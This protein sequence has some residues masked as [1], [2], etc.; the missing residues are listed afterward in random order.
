MS[1]RM[2]VLL[3]VG[4]WL[5]GTI[6]LVILIGGSGENAEFAP[7]EEFRLTPWIPIQV[8]PFDLSINKAV[9][10]L[11]IATALTVITMT[12]IARRMVDKPNRVQAA[13]EAVFTLS[14]DTITRDNMSDEMAV[15]WFPFIGT[16]FLFILFSNLIGYLPLPTNTGETISVFGLQIP[17]L[18]IYAA[19]ANLSVPLALTLVVWIA[20]QVEGVRAKG[21]IAYVKG[22]IPQGSPPALVPMIGFIEVLS[23]IMRI[24][25]LSV[26]LFAN[27]LAGHMLILFMGGGLAVLLGLAALG[28]LTA[29]IA[30]VFFLFEVVI[31][32]GLQAFIFATLTS[33]YLGEAVAEGH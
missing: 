8:G 10:Y 28:W 11:A 22:W 24:V 21:P 32:A 9:L 5:G 15:R 31:V 26:R 33:I 4:T 14:R 16:L 18:A 25:S 2:K 3:G 27:I 17:A 30:I 7:I 1:T 29:P 19:T 23:Q 20:Y 12:Y 13:V 6:L